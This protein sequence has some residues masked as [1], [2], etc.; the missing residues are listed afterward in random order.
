MTL[1]RYKIDAITLYGIDKPDW[2]SER[3]N[4]HRLG[5]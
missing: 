5:A 1:T 3:Y 2:H 4:L